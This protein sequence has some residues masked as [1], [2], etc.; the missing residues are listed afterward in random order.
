VLLTRGAG[1]GGSHLQV[2]RSAKKQGLWETIRAR[3]PKLQPCNHVIGRELCIA[4]RPR[5]MAYIC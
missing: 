3:T 4:G 2:V 5:R 1:R